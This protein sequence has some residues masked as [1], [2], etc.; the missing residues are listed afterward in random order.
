MPIVELHLLQGYDAAD[1]RRLG[2]A[3]T[4][5]VRFVVP[6]APELITIM[7]HE[8]VPENYYRGRTARSPAPALP[9]PAQTVRTYLQAMEKRDL[10]TARQL[11]GD[12]FV[13]QFPG[14]Q[15]MTGLEEL[16]EWAAPR[17]RYVT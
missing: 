7:I 10:D 15:A 2:Q 11:L 13:M 1:K 5:A 16:I 9:D 17:Y 8:M 12:G 6:A 14:A 4:D 3:L